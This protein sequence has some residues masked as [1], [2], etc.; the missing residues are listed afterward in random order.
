MSVINP[1][2]CLRH[3]RWTMLDARPSEMRTCSH[4]GGVGEVPRVN[5]GWTVAWM[6]GVTLAIGAVLAGLMELVVG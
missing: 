5:L 6:A 3:H 2:A 4:C 1:D